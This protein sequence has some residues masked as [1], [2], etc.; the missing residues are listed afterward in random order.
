MFTSKI[1]GNSIFVPA[2][3]YRNGSKIYDEGSRG[4]AWLS[5]LYA[6]DH[7]FAWYLNLNSYGINANINDYYRFDGRSIRP[8][9]RKS[10][11]TENFD[12]N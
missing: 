1:N 4:H 8:V 2:A 11:L 5:N 9:F 7:D 10:K 6:N 3:G 12:F